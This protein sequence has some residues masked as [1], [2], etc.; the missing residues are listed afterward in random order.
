MSITLLGFIMMSYASL[1][2]H[3]GLEQ[4][5]EGGMNWPKAN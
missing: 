4:I 5:S 2:K 1:V 3:S